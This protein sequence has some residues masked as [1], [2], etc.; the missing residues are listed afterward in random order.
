LRASTPGKAY[1]LSRRRET[2]VSEAVEQHAAAIIQ[3][4]RSELEA[5]A[6]AVADLPLP[7]ISVAPENVLANLAFLVPRNST[8]NFATA[9][10]QAARD[11]QISLE[12]SGPWPP[13]S[14]VNLNVGG[15]DG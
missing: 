13:Y 15:D 6:V 14:F 9:A 8:D 12:L 1:L 2:A 3:Q 11:A 10:D 7:A 4:V 5:R